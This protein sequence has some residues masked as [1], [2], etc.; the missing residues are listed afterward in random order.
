MLRLH[1][2][3]LAGLLVAG[4]LGAALPARA[5]LT[6]SPIKPGF[7]TF[8]RQKAAT[9]PDIAAACRDHFEVQFADGRFFGVRTRK[10]ERNGVHREIDDVGRCTFDRAAQADRCDIKSIH[11]DG[12]V[13]AGTMENKYSFEPDKT[14][15]MTVT[16]KLITDTPLSNLPFDVFPVRCPDDA[17]WN[18][19]NEI[20]SPK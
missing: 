11:D 19:L 4:L 2:V 10:A 13:L 16:P 9:A 8:P 20:P 7:W 3:A 17:V 5:Q 15:K 6:E 1:R 14:L 12:S 18:S